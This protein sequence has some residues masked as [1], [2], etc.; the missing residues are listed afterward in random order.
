MKKIV[1][2]FTIIA[3]LAACADE[4]STSEST[5]STNKPAYEGHKQ[6]SWLL[7]R[8]ENNS[9]QGNLSEVWE[10]KNDSLYI[11]TSYFEI[12]G[13][14]VFNE[15]VELIEKDGV[16][17]YIVSISEGDQGPVPFK[18][19]KSSDTELVFENPKHDFPQM[20]TYTHK[21]DSVIAIISGK[22]KGKPK[23]EVFAMKKTN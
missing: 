17:N 13:D 7:G 16:L 20:I 6:A 21:G 19:T 8:W 22:E 4:Q 9:D 3:L 11:G 10:K 14:T 1:F 2:S 15:S 12:N 23:K 5:E 18:L